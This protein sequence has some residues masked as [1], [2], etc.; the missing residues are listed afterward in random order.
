MS[1]Q[2]AAVDKDIGVNGRVDFVAIEGDEMFA[3]NRLT[4]EIS[5]K[6]KLSLAEQNKKHRLII[7][8][9]DKGTVLGSLLFVFNMLFI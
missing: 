6:A 5:V 4:G 2:V 9:R 8:A 3:I 7:E 1:R